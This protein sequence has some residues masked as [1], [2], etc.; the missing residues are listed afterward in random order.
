MQI[1]ITMNLSLNEK[2]FKEKEKIHKKFA[3]PHTR[4]TRTKTMP[5]V[6]KKRES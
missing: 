4:A 5:A 2:I 6:D 3:F 1:M